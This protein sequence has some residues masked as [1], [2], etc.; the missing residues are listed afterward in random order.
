MVIVLIKA[1]LF[2]FFRTIFD[3]SRD[4]ERLSGIFKRILSKYGVKGKVEGD[5]LKEVIDNVFRKAKEI[6]ESSI[7]QIPYHMMIKGAFKEVF[8]IDLDNS[9]VFAIID[10]T[11]KYSKFH[12]IT[13]LKNLLRRIKDMG[14]YVGLISNTAVDWPVKVLKRYGIPSIRC[15]HL[16]QRIRCEETSS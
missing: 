3:Y 4:Y 9:E 13:D 1:I 15:D 6:E 16:I 10:V 5:S 11:S 2:D 12:P 8:G 7:E 14:M